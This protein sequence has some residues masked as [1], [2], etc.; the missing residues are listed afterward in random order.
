MGPIEMNIEHKSL[1]AGGLGPKTYEMGTLIWYDDREDNVLFQRTLKKLG[2]YLK[3][4]GFRGDIDVNCIVNEN[5]IFPLELTARFGFPSTQLQST[6]N[7]SSW[8]EFLKAVSDGKRYSLRYKREYG[9]VVLIAVPPFPYMAVS[10]K[11]SLQKIVT[12]RLYTEKNS[13]P[14]PDD[15]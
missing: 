2:D 13:E 5:G 3:A 1:C 9:I 14:L 10:K 4:I 7:I 6:L 12:G 11:Y 8:G 15:A